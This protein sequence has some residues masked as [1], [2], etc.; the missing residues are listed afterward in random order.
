MAASR[1]MVYLCMATKRLHCRDIPHQSCHVASAG[2]A[3]GALQHGRDT[4]TAAL[5]CCS[6]RP[7]LTCYATDAGSLVAWFHR[8]GN[9]TRALLSHAAAPLA[10]LALQAPGMSSACLGHGDSATAAPAS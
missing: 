5:A 9:A 7:V 2:T 8:L 6:H 1:L 3:A 4:V 10:R